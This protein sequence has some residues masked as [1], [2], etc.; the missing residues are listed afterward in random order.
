MF[1]RQCSASPREKQSRVARPGT[2]GVK[3]AKGEAEGAGHQGG[4]R[5]GPGVYGLGIGGEGGYGRANVVPVAKGGKTG[6]Y[7]LKGA[8]HCLQ[9]KDGQRSGA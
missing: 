8:V 4:N 5:A 3:G 2:A 7:K 6:K 1:Q 9:T